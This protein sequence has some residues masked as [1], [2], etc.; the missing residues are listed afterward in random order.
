MKI[1]RWFHKQKLEMKIMLAILLSIGLVAGIY[2][3]KYLFAIIFPILI[4]LWLSTDGKIPNV[5]KTESVIY[6]PEAMHEVFSFVV[7]KLRIFSNNK[8]YLKSW[9]EV[10][11]N[12]AGTAKLFEVLCITDSEDINREYLK[13]LSDYYLREYGEQNGYNLS[14]SPFVLSTHSVSLLEKEVNYIVLRYIFATDYATAQEFYC[15][16]TPQKLEKK[17]VKEVEDEDF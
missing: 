15:D 11:E 3:L 16:I 1:L 9:N 10:R 2:L 5:W 7:R 4:L 14:P 13:E 17:I 8:L 12:R 6:R